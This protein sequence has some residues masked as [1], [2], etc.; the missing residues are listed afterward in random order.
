M[1]PMIP[2]D[3]ARDPEL[4]AIEILDAVLDA[5]TRALLAAHPELAD[6]ERPYWLTPPTPSCHAARSI[7][8]R[9]ARLRDRLA[10][11]R[12]AVADENSG[13]VGADDFPF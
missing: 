12:S 2:K 10:D 3:L 9:A 11:Y 8:D 1:T 13:P 6:D 5:T 7:V 4:A